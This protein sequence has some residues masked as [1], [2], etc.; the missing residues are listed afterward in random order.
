MVPYTT[1]TI[2]Y[3]LEGLAET[4]YPVYANAKLERKLWDSLNK[5]YQAED[6]STKK[7]IVGKMLEL[8]A[9]LLSPRLRSLRHH[10]SDCREKK[11]Q[12][13]KKKTTEA[14][15]AKLDNLD[16]CAVVTE[17]NLIGSNPREWFLDTGAT[18]TIFAPIRAC[19]MNSKRPPV[20]SIWSTNSAFKRVIKAD[21]RSF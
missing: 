16:L 7:F 14:M 18:H 6:V 12:K 17:V 21:F 1:L 11:P 10:S 2:N 8:T 19:F 15:C 9:N 20:T 3:I 13:N 5:K 4:L